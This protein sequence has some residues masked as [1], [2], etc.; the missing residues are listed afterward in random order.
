MDGNI[1]TFLISVHMI[2]EKYSLKVQEIS[3]Y[4]YTFQFHEVI[5]GGY[6]LPQ[7]CTSM[8]LVY[9]H[10][11]LIDGGEKPR[12][13]EIGLERRRGPYASKTVFPL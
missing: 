7:F 11:Y 3:L 13:Q 4:S 12:P 6:F 9:L 1:N 2:E 10:Y 5:D 8:L